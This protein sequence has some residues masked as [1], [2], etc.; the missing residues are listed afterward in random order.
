MLW[1]ADSVIPLSRM[2]HNMHKYYYIK[3]DISWDD[4]ER[5]KFLR[6]YFMKYFYYTA[7][8]KNF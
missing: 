7:S 5:L 6:E 8:L 4:G 2:I 1:Y 3:L